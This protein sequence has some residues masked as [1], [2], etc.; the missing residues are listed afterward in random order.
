VPPIEPQ[1]RLFASQQPVEPSKT[2][3]IGIPSKKK[4]ATVPALDA[5]TGK[6]PAALRTV[7]NPSPT[8]TSRIATATRRDRV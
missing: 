2:S 4:K 6:S 3:R 1:I 7:K 8:V 5:T